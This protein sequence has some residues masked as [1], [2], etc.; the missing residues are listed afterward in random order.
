M[1]QKKF[2]KR[3]ARFLSTKFFFRY[4][5]KVLC[6]ERILMQKIDSENPFL[7]P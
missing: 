4:D 2:K 1:Q 3:G 5:K 7:N 6:W